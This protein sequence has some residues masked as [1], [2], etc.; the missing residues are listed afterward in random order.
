MAL[1]ERNA[2]VSGTYIDHTTGGVG[3]KSFTYPA[4][5][6]DT[7]VSTNPGGENPF[8]ARHMTK[9]G[10][11]LSG[12]RTGFVTWVDTPANSYADGFPSTTIPAPSDSATRL[13][14]LTNPGRAE[15]LLPTFAWELREVPG[16]LYQAL[17]VL[18]AIRR[19]L[20]WRRVVQW[21]RP[22][23]VAAANLAVQFGWAPLIGDLQKMGT[24]MDATNKRRGELERLHSPSGLKRRI[25]LASLSDKYTQPKRAQWSTHGVV[26]YQS[27][28][29]TETLTSW[30][31]AKWRA[32]PQSSY[33]K[34]PLAPSNDEIRRLLLG[35]TAPHIIEN[36]WEALP[37]S[38]LLDWIIPIQSAMQARNRIVA[39]PAGG[40]VMTQ[41]T[42]EISWQQE[43]QNPT[44]WL[45]S[46]GKTSFT[47][48]FRTVT[49]GPSSLYASV[50]FLSLKQLSVLGSLAILRAR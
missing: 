23:N 48:N 2:K 43:P 14:A 47:R 27:S 35:M 37:W 9:T 29:V 20:N 24:L 46:A 22:S 33:L 13:W 40:C 18:I 36:L 1:K 3:V 32:N 11:I 17:R 6:L 42:V 45:L 12:Y 16:M 41:R 15:L 38:W 28:Y 8:A 30:G 25:Q 44:S 31:V 5:Y 39:I 50:P 10:C 4:D 26:V 49:P 21:S 7:S 19:G 34:N